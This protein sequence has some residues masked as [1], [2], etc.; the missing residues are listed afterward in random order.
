VSERVWTRCLAAVT[1]RSGRLLSLDR[2]NAYLVDAAMAAAIFVPAA[3]VLVSIDGLRVIPFI[4][5]MTL[6]L[7]GRRSMPLA[8]Y[9]AQCVGFVMAGALVPPVAQFVACFLAVL[10][11]AY[12]TGRYETSWTR[13]LGIVT[14]SIAPDAALAVHHGSTLNA[15]WF[16]Q[17]IVAWSA[18][19]SVR[20]QIE[21]A[22]V[23]TSP[24]APPAAQSAALAG[25]TTR[26]VEVLRL[27]AR[28]H[29]NGEVA[30]LLHIGQGTVKT[31]VA[32]ILHKLGLRD[33]VQAVVHAYETGLVAPRSTPAPRDEN[34]S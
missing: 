5:A 16:L 12:S 25:L 10:C 8:A 9:A 13:S 27:L 32:R 7:V 29:T 1:D 26:E 17:L 6:P 34:L 21:R 31:H 19:F 4:A 14:V 33:R 30:E 22:S 28:G 15:L 20:R 2:L 3:V 24:I 11:G 18:G 23:P